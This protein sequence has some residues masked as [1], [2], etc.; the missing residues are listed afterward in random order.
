[1]GKSACRRRHYNH[2]PPWQERVDTPSG[3]IFWRTRKL[4]GLSPNLPGL[5]LAHAAQG[6]VNVVISSIPA[7]VR[8][9]RF[10]KAK[11][12]LMGGYHMADKCCDQRAS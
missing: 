4:P 1:M 11:A 7:V 10:F 9:D 3:G 12:K 5:P 6:V 8:Y 2:H